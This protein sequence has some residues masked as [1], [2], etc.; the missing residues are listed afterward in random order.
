MTPQMKLNRQNLQDLQC[1]RDIG[2]EKLKQVVAD[3]GGRSVAPIHPK[4]LQKLMDHALG[5]DPVAA[6]VLLRQ[7]LSLHGMRRQL[8]LDSGDIISGITAGIRCDS[9]WDE[10][11]IGQWENASE[12]FQEL[13]DLPIVHLT[14]K[15]LDLSY[16]HSHLLQSSHVI[17]DIRPL[18]NKD[19]SEIQGTT[20]SHKLL[21]R[22]D[23]VEGEHGL[24]VALDERDLK[25]L[26]RQC[27]RAL[28]KSRTTQTQL[29]KKANLETLIPG[30]D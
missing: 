27:E 17:T 8:D 2:A 12:I 29:K 22:Y 15:A 9:G 7:L 13:F 26:I 6:G 21:L 25:A 23:D 4:E 19:A 20:I 11:Q 28:T 30:A 3:V 18:F 16:Q 24:S 10:S 14:A 5:G 1:I